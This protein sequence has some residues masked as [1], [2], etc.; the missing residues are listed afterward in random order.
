MSSGQATEPQ[1]DQAPHPGVQ[2]MPQWELKEL[3]ADRSAAGNMMLL[4]GF[5]VAAVLK[6]AQGSSTV[7]MIVASAIMADIVQSMGTMPY[8][9][10]YLATAI[11]GGSLIGSWM[12]DSGFWVVSKMS[13]IS[14]PDALRTWTVL[15]FV[16]GCTSLAITMVLANVMP[17]TR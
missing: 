1:A 4:L 16:L 3:F 2:S 13:G 10:V 9:S 17:L 14:E 5:A 6:V 12:N 8:H 11:G 7:A 15:L